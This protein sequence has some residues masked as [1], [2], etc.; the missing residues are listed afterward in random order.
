MKAYWRAESKRIEAFE[1]RS[2]WL[3]SRLGEAQAPM[4]RVLS[5]QAPAPVEAKPTFDVAAF[6][7]SFEAAL[8]KTD[9]ALATLSRCA[10]WTVSR[11]F[12]CGAERSAAEAWC[13]SSICGPC[14]EA[15]A[16][17]ASGAAR[18]AWSGA[19]VIVA[20][21]P[22]GTQGKLKLPS[23]TAVLAARDGWARATKLAPETSKLEG[24]PR[25]ITHP[26]GLRVFAQPPIG[27]EGGKIDALAKTLE[28]A[29]RQLGLKGTTV[30]AVSKNDAIKRMADAFTLE[31]RRF[32]ET[33]TADLKAHGAFN[34][35]SFGWVEHAR[36]RQKDRR[37]LVSGGRDALAVT[38]PRGPSL[39][40]NACPTHGAGCAETASVVRNAK[41]VVVSRAKPMGAKPTRQAFATLVTTKPQPA[42]IRKAG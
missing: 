15:R 17:E 5:K 3:E 42:K 13:G 22:L 1:T 6:A 36:S 16:S 12:G 18:T 31:A 27:V 25:A 21:I 29:L 9:G 11:E 23:P 2:G 10:S 4:I 19:R 8:G 30:R 32:Q 39:E 35:A 7:A 14:A 40:P 26:D 33:I 38:E 24:L 37:A 41:G 20:D 34:K 28:A